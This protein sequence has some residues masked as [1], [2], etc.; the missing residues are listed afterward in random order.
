[1]AENQTK[2]QDPGLG[3]GYVRGAKRQINPDGSFNVVRK[4]RGFT[5]RS[6]YK[7]LI[8]CS[9]WQFF[10]IIFLGYLIFNLFFAGAYY[11]VG[12]REL[13][14]VSE[15]TGWNGFVQSFFFSVQTF[16][17]VGYGGISPTGLWSGFIASFE[18]F[19]GLLAFAFATG[20]LYGRFSKPVANLI[21]SDKAVVAPHKGAKAFMFRVANQRTNV[22]MEADATVIL[23]TLHEENGELK[24][25]YRRLDLQISSIVFFPM[26]W[27]IVHEIT[28]ESPMYNMTE[29]D[30]EQQGAEILILVS[31][32]D[33]TFSQRIYRRYSYR[34][35]E[36]VWNAK[37]ERPFYSDSDGNTIF[38]MEKL[39]AIQTLESE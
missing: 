29:K 6:A 8:E 24:R 32:F 30:F 21:F 13:S 37:F 9:W 38:E 16:T 5:V 10:G 2:F 23:M 22:L 26:N 35:K 7:F 1:M 36:V 18:A 14:G 31:G 4:G 27:T 12:L 11:L 39:S 15:H 20:L 25:L 28:P 34:W 19:F 17:T 33:D 3:Q